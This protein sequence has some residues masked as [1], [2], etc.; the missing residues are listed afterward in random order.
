MNVINRTSIVTCT[1]SFVVI[2]VASLLC[3]PKSEPSP[4]V[5]SPKEIRLTSPDG[6]RTLRITCENNGASIYMTNENGTQTA[7]LFAGDTGSILTLG[8]EGQT[9]L[10]ATA[11]ESNTWSEEPASSIRLTNQHGETKLL[12]VD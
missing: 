10:R 12:A 11:T 1:L 6:S 3:W 7:H 4:T 2:A 5:F 8:R 9:M